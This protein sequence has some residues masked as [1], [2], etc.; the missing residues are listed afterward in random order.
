MRSNL[1]SWLQR[2]IRRAG[3]DIARYPSQSVHSLTGHTARLIDALEIDCVVDVGAN[4]G[5]YG[6]MLRSLGYDG[7]IVSFEPVQATFRQLEKR[8][9]KDSNW[10]AVHLALGSS[11][12][13]AMI[14]VTSSTVLASLRNPSS[15]SPGWMHPQ[16][17]I[18]ERQSVRVARL[19]SIID[20]LVGPYS[21]I[22]LKL[23]TQGW[24]MEVLE[25][26]SECMGRIVAVQT[27]LSVIPIYDGMPGWL[28]AMGS[29]SS[30]GFE[31]TWM[32]PVTLDGPIRV[33]E[34]DCVMVRSQDLGTSS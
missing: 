34:F 22:L 20:E 4:I 23:D 9:A 13:D 7:P 3:L 10:M 16:L 5:Q 29:L 33:L 32:S 18:D 8:T 25:G 27:E 19:D 15:G 24:D 2:Q 21:R 31:P 11:N 14:N 6:E 1:F 30:R 26:A 28:E 17:Q 12:G